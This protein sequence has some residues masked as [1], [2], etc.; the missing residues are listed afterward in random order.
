MQMS[1]GEVGRFRSAWGCF[2]VELSY[3]GWGGV[4]GCSEGVVLRE[5]VAV[6][7]VY[8]G[9]GDV[10]RWRDAGQVEVYCAGGP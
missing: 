5:D 8:A 2:L 7:G 10:G 6:A 9:D 3:L 4:L 1:V